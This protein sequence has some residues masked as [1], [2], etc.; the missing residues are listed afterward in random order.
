MSASL[1]EID[2]VMRV[3]DAFG[4]GRHVSVV[5]RFE[6][7]AG[8]T[9]LIRVDGVVL[10]LKAW[11]TPSLL[12]R[13][14]PSALDR[15][16]RMRAR[17]IPIPTVVENGHAAGCEYLLYEVLAGQWPARV[18]NGVLGGLLVCVD[19]ERDAAG[20]RVDQAS[21]VRRMLTDGDP[22]SDIDPAVVN[23]HPVGR[24]FLDEARTRL[25]R[26]D[27]T[28]LRG[29][30]IV[31]GDFAPENLL[32]DG[33]RVTGVVDWERCRVG[34]AGFDM[35]GALYDMEIGEK[36]ERQARRDFARALLDRVQA[37]PLDLCL[38]VYAVR[39][40]SWAIGTTMQDDV[41]RLA[42][43]LVDY[44]QSVDR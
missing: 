21:V 15:M 2:P 3:A 7:G 43:R 22:L 12:S 36:A 5:H 31:H 28:E 20:E 1:H 23:T 19:A 44:R 25:E 13:H 41:L 9:S 34:D 38:A 17:G 16:A 39:Y 14:L 37:A 33:D 40:A 42:M 4:E 24:R 26:C 32:V 30:D 18:T 27:P 11:A 29:G 35:V 8:G 10:V 6:H